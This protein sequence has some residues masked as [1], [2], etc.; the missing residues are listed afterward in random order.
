MIG[1]WIALSVLLIIVIVFLLR[2][3]IGKGK[4][5]EQYK[6]RFLSEKGELCVEFEKQIQHLKLQLEEAESLAI[7]SRQSE[8]AI[9]LMDAGGNIVWTNDS[10]TRMYE[11]TYEEFISALGKNI[12][13]TSFSSEITD[14]LSHCYNQKK[15]VSYDA[16]NIT[17]N[18]KEIWTRTSLVP[19]LDA[20]RKV[21]GLVTIDSDIDSRVKAGDR[22][23]EYIRDFN[24]KTEAISE[25]LNVMVELTNIMFERIDVSQ[26]RIERTDQI[27]N[28]IKGIADQTK[29][30]GINASI[31]AH[32][33]GDYGRGFRV[34]ANEIVNISSITNNSL[35]EIYELIDKIQRGSDKLGTEKERAETA[36]EKH[37]SLITDLKSEI[38]EVE[39]VVMQLK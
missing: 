24:Q 23:V 19:L 7:V 14:R 33:A 37:R 1:P 6:Q 11:Y 35:R 25:Q 5:F 12:R 22:M 8:N 30:L 34:I 32:A 18:G 4:E 21:I 26:R 3:L 15:S 29:I 31:E 20:N 38:N 27:I 2:R 28:F 9:M 16:P 39:S 17:K 36:I 10:F 13:Q